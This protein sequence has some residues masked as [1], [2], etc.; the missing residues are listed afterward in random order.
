MLQNT[1]LEKNNRKFGTDVAHMF[2]TGGYVFDINKEW[3]LKPSTML[4][5]AVESPISADVSVRSKKRCGWK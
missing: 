2:L 4:K 3:K 1:Y 5:M